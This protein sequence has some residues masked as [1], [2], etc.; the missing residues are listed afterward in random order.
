M[1]CPNL[2][3]AGIPG[4]QHHSQLSLSLS[5]TQRGPEASVPL[6][7]HLRSLILQ[8]LCLPGGYPGS[9]L[10]HRLGHFGHSLFPS[11]SSSLAQFF[12]FSVVEPKGLRTQLR[13][14]EGRIPGSYHWLC[15]ILSPAFMWSL[16]VN[17]AH[18]GQVLA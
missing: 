17:L 3:G 13:S 10:H 4:V 7:G 9:G 15:F 5:G 16:V 8:P 14:P 6:E 12:T 11:A 18:T 2:P 1:T